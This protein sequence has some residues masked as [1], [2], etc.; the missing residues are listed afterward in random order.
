MRSVFKM[1]FS[2]SMK[3]VNRPV[4]GQNLYFRIG[5]AGSDSETVFRHCY[6]WDLYN[7]VDADRQKNVRTCDPGLLETK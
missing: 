5:W 6:S 7:N 1:L 3:L 4:L 2:F